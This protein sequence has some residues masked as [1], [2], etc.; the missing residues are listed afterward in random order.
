MQYSSGGS[1]DEGQKQIIGLDRSSDCWIQIMTLY[2][3]CDFCHLL[4]TVFSLMKERDD[5]LVR[6][7]SLE[8]KLIAKE[9]YGDIAKLQREIRE[10]Q[11]ELRG[12]SV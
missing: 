11:E 1:R 8:A 6:I 2:G 3:N 12:A 9:G 4:T 7:N 10:L 5:A